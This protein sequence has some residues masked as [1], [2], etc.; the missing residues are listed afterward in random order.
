M[1]LRRSARTPAK[2]V[3]EDIPEAAPTPTAKRQRAEPKPRPNTTSLQYLLT[4]PRSKLCK[5]N[6]SDVF[7][8]KTW[9]LLS[10]DARKRLLPLLPPTAFIDYTPKIDASHPSNVS[11]PSDDAMDIDQ[12]PQP[13]SPQAGERS[14][15]LLAP[16][17]LKCHFLQSAA[18]QYQDQIASGFF[19][20]K[21]VQRVQT[22][23][24][25]VADGTAHARWKDDEWDEDHPSESEEE[26]V[27]KSSTAKG[28]AKAAPSRKPTFVPSIPELVENRL[29]R[30][31]D[32]LVY[33]RGF[34]QP[35]LVVQKHLL[36]QS[37]DESSG[38]V[39]F[40]LPLGTTTSF[41][42][43]VLTF[44]AEILPTIP[45][46]NLTPSLSFTNSPRKPLH[47][48]NEDFD[49]FPNSSTARE[50]QPD[51]ISITTSTSAAALES[52]LLPLYN[53][54]PPEKIHQPDSNSS[55]CFT[56]WRWKDEDAAMGGNPN[57][58]LGGRQSIGNL[59]Y[60]SQS[61]PRR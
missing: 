32:L 31:G 38:T 1:A 54:L 43:D 46:T 6:I 10:E 56:V 39:T 36:V 35:R 55:K 48:T 58:R 17:F 9:E 45:T 57:A 59:H 34:A 21:S 14:L 20:E 8:T 16:N 26:P 22:Y 44:P 50:P 49:D 13:Q 28:K 4:N 2:R 37:V 53:D 18:Q 41:N 60:L 7:N 29:L 5:V 27:A 30:L 23:N 51:Y 19:T 52:H 15:D 12:I 40:L 11:K 33:K 42:D 47:R 25:A 61:C 3:I 24:E